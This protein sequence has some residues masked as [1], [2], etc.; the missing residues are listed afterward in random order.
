MS[1]RGDPGPRPSRRR[2]RRTRA[3]VRT[4]SALARAG[5]PELG[6]QVGRAVG[7]AVRQAARELERSVDGA[8][9]G[10][11]P[12]RGGLQHSFELLW[13]MIKFTRSADGEERLKAFWGLVSLRLRRPDPVGAEDLGPEESAA[14]RAE[15]R[16]EAVR[17]ACIIGSMGLGLA[18]L[19][20]L[21]DASFWRALW[22]VSAVLMFACAGGLVAA[23]HVERLRARF[24]DEELGRVEGAAARGDAEESRALVMSELAASIAHEIRNPITAA[25]S[26]VQQMGDS[27]GAAE[28]L[29]YAQ[30]AL[31]ELDRVERSVSHLLRFAREEEV[32]PRE[33]RLADVVREALAILEER[34]AKAGV[35]LL[36]E[37]TA[38]GALRGDPDKLRRVVLNLVGNAIDAL[39]DTPGAKVEVGVG[40]NLA[41]TEVWL[42]VRDNGPGIPEEERE[43]VFR[44]FHTTRDQ[45]T[46]LG[47]AIT[48]KLVEVHGGTVEVT[49]SPSGGAEFLVTLPRASGQ[50]ASGG[51]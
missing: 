46:G 50:G 45:G 3:E 34:A 1:D 15:Q 22:S 23:A 33:L 41:A 5:L 28:N 6:E 26:L 35:E 20:S 36:P 44:P 47:L 2:K 49:G 10:R 12:A 13:G 39:E 19:G 29:E 48:R 11:R 38:A 4:R 16:W 43:R 18:F 40:E 30:V 27:P 24:L 37:V 21:S 7:S 42:R 31:E 25:K 51:P 32:E 17:A 8:V 14:L 9:G